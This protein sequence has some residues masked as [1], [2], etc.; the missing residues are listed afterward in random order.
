MG[1]T[2]KSTGRKFNT[3]AENLSF[4]TDGLVYS[5][6]DSVEFAQDE[7][8]EFKCDLTQD[9]KKELAEMMILKWKEFGGITTC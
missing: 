3:E 9:E 6:Y 1:I 7:D 2:F 8:G 5:G 4:G